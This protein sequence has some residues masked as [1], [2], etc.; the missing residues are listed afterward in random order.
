LIRIHM[1]NGC[2]SFCGNEIDIMSVFNIVDTKPETKSLVL[3]ML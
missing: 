1:P 2:D 3:E